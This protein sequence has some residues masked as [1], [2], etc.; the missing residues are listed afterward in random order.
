MRAYRVLALSYLAALAT[1]A[2]LA[3][4]IATLLQCEGI[5]HAHVLGGSYSGAIAQVLVRRHPTLVASLISRTLVRLHRRGAAAGAAA[6]PF[7]LLPMPLL[8]LLLYALNYGL[9]G[10]ARSSVSGARILRR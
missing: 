4:G 1:A 10:A 8:R 2:A 3:D 6:A 7:K 9:R 5:T